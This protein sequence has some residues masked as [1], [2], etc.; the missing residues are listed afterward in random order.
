VRYNYG[1]QALQLTPKVTLG[2][3]EAPDLPTLWTAAAALQTAGYLAPSQ[4]QPLDEVLN[5]QA[6]EADELPPTPQEQAD[7]QQQQLQ[8]QLDAKTQQP[9][10]NTPQ[11]GAA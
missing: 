6:R 5:L 11:K 8:M 7:Q 2:K 4:L 10:G 3:A 9:A 1:E